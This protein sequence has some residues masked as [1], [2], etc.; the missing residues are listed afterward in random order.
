MDRSIK[1]AS[2]SVPFTPELGRLL[3]DGAWL[4][5]EG[6]AWQRVSPANAEVMWEGNWASSSQVDRAVGA[7]RQAFP[8]WSEKSLDE[9]MSVCRKFA[10]TLKARQEEL[11]SIVARETGKPLWEART[12]VG[13]AATKVANSFDAILK[14]RWTTTEEMG[15]LLAVTRYRP[16]GVMLVLGPFNLPAHLPGA[17][18]VPALLAGNTIVFKRVSWRSY[19]TVAGRSMALRRTAGGGAEPAPRRCRSGDCSGRACRG[20]RSALH[21]KPPSGSQIASDARRKTS[22]NLGSRTGREQSLGGSRGPAICAALRSL[23]FNRPTSPQG[24]AVRAHGD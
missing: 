8:T 5:G 17:H 10:E 13:A 22:Q 3:I 1:P 2:D 23:P 14:R 20:G 12:E 7:A 6:V 15:D 4:S 9:R 21:R 11:A 16:H 19:R 18:I 24:N